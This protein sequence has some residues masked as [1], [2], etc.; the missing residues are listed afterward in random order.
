MLEP[1]IFL[2]PKEVSEILRLNVLTVYDYIRN[3]EL[4]AV[5]LGRSY[6]IEEKELQK[7]IQM[8]LTKNYAKA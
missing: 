8:H 1:T 6:R 2:T 5:R 7:F 4:E 3:G